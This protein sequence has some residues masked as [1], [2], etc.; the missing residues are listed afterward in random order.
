MAGAQAGAPAAGV[1][2][3]RPPG[4]LGRPKPPAPRP[5]APSRRRALGPGSAPSAARGR[6]GASHPRGL[7]PK[8][9]KVRA[10]HARRYQQAW[11]P[12]RPPLPPPT[13]GWAPLGHTRSSKGS[14]ASLQ[15]RGERPTPRPA[16]DPRELPVPPSCPQVPWGTPW[17]RLLLAA[18]I[19]GTGPDHGATHP[20]F[21]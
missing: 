5:G 9:V 10:G 6:E 18:P 19:P 7:E 16:P 11:P 15:G 2:A 3:P 4:A 20:S 13:L 14:V 8:Q 1:R 21:T 12:A 17:K